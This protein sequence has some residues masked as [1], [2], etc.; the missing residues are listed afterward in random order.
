MKNLNL[1]IFS[2]IFSSSLLATNA[3]AD[4]AIFEGTCGDR[5]VYRISGDE[6]TMTSPYESFVGS[7]GV[8]V[9]I[10]GSTYR[11]NRG[12]LEAQLEDVNGRTTPCFLAQ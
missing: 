2:L 3:S 11:V 9:S 6:V 12:A 7:R 1:A 8:Y 4:T 10:N 5:E